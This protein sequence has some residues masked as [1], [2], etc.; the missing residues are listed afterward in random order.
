[1]KYVY[2]ACFYK[3]EDGRYSVDIP[4]FSVTTFGDDLA[5]ALYMAADAIAGRI[6]LAIRNGEPIPPPSDINDVIPDEP[7]FSSM[8]YVDIDV[9][10]PAHEEKPVK[11]NTYDSFMAQC[12]C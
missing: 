2:P 8:V 12:R 7:G 10:A 11:K 6:H 1:M 4:D 9:T 3:E 5:D